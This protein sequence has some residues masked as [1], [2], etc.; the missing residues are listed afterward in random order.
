[1]AP[2]DPVDATTA[3]GGAA[4]SSTRSTSGASPTATATA[5]ATSPAS[6]PGCRTSATSAST[7]SGSRPWYVSPLADGGYDVADYRA[8]DPAFG[9]LEEAER[10]DRRGRRARDP[11]HRR[12]R[13]QPHLRPA[14]VVPGRARAPPGSPERARF[15]FHPGG[16]QHGDEMPDGLGVQLLRAD[17]DAGRPNPDGTPG[18][19]YLHLFAA[20]AAR[21]ELG[22]PRRP[23][24]ARG[25]SCGSGSTAGAAG[26]RIDSA[27][28][29]VKDPSLP[30][31]PAEPGPASTRT[32]TATSSTTSTGAGGPIADAYPGDADPRR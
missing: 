6:G 4:P 15:W 30:E 9:T 29:L 23:P 26:I 5:S 25:R 24:R 19:W 12:R 7:P 17:L 8:I 20:A 11:D 10:A 21:P 27:A 28:L 14:P 18:E 22:P 13:P 3:R 16:V 2:A 32:P 1:M 31:V